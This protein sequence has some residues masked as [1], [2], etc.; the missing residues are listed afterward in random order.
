[1]SKAAEKGLYCYLLDDGRTALTQRNLDYATNEKGI[2]DLNEVNK[3]DAKTVNLIADQK[4]GYMLAELY[5]KEWTDPDL[6]VGMTDRERVDLPYY[7]HCSVLS[8]GQIYV[9]AGKFIPLSQYVKK[10]TPAEMAAMLWDVA[11]QAAL[12][13]LTMIS[14]QSFAPDEAV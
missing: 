11:V 10:A 8:Q 7:Q 4:L 13:Q 3:A 9:R 14:D 12:A 6:A 2:L 1:M 5:G